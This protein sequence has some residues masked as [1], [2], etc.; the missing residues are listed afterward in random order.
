MYSRVTLLE[1]DPL[2]FDLAGAL[3]RFQELVLPELRSQPGYEGVVVLANQDAKGLVMT[4]W[5]SQEDAD[6]ALLN[7]FWA[8]QVE[9]FVTLFAAPPGREGYEVVFSETPALTPQ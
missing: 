1:F 7:G 6:A 5:A 2:R 4:L 9:Q 3:E 8:A